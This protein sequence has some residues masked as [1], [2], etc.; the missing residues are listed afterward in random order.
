MQSRR[1]QVQAY[2]FVVGRLVSALMRAR[3][4]EPAPPHR[5]FGTGFFGGVLLAALISA[6]FG[7]YGLIVPSG[8]DSWRAAGTII[9]EEETG[10]RYLYLDGLLHPVLNY[11]SA[12]LAVN[13]ARGQVS[14][15]SQRSLEGVP[16]GVPIGIPNAPDSLPAAADMTDGP[17]LSCA[18]TTTDEAGQDRPATTLLVAGPGGITLA[19][20]EGLLVVG[21][22]DQTH[23]VWQGRKYRFP[24]G[25]IAAALGYDTVTP[26]RVTT[27]W[28]N[29]LPTGPDLG[30]PE[31]EGIGEP[32]API[33]NSPGVVG[34]IYQVDNPVIDATEFYV[35]RR[36]GLAAVSPTMASLA[37]ASPATATAY[38]AGG[39]RPIAIGPEALAGAP[40]SSA[41]IA[42]TDHPNTPPT[43]V[44][45]D[46]SASVRPCVRFTLG[47]TDGPDIAVS[48]VDRDTVDGPVSPAR[49]TE[50]GS[51]DR[52]LVPPNSGVL[53]RDLPAPGVDGGTH[54]LV[55]DLGV[56]YPLASTQ[57]A[58]TLGYGGSRSV[59]VPGELLA[60]LPTGPV[61][62][63]EQAIRPR[64]PVPPQS[65]GDN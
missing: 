20:G 38:P 45:L 42:G 7:V 13:D 32:T 24:D 17:W 55:T 5:R 65:E 26:L 21:P 61:L 8:N 28:I 19:D 48:M 3:T 41:P 59:P 43:L 16:R 9:V 47:S 37:L 35:L 56:K 36:D 27:S 52:V 53:V 50:A 62:D 40:R 10:A 22:D 4:D 31:V 30:P 12:R 15:V 14:Q 29:A 49:G 63:P 2:F 64:Q 44:D 23:L 57:V 51:A 54:Y 33:G 1:D 58:A 25:T 39:V 46:G 18:S 34:Q 11:A 60:A 6:G